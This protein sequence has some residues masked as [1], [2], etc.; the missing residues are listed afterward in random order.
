DKRSRPCAPLQYPLQPLCRWPIRQETRLLNAYSYA[1]TTS[2]P[3]LL[4]C[5]GDGKA[6]SGSEYRSRVKSGHHE[7]DRSSERYTEPGRVEWRSG[8]CDADK[9]AEC[10]PG[11]ASAGARRRQR[12]RQKEIL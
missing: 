2:D 12:N 4:D 6:C 10:P 1:Q 8:G 5:D 9:Y 3:V 7:A 11:R